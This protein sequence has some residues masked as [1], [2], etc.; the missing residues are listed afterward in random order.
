MPYSISLMT[1]FSLASIDSSEMSMAGLAFVSSSCPFLGLLARRE[2]EED[3]TVKSDFK[4]NV[5][6]SSLFS[7]LRSP[8]LKK[9]SRRAKMS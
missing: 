4:R 6:G 5:S 1:F 8:P 2:R 9:G 3:E 7:P